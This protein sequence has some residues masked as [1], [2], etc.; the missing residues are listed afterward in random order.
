MHIRC[1]CRLVPLP[2]G[3]ICESNWFKHVHCNHRC[4][5]N[6]WTILN[7]KCRPFSFW[8]VLVL[9]NLLWGNFISF[10]I[11]CFLSGLQTLFPIT[12]WCF[13]LDLFGAITIRVEVHAYMWKWP[14]Y[15]TVRSKM[16]ENDDCWRF[17]SIPIYRRN[18][19]KLLFNWLST[20]YTK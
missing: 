4:Q 19:L 3:S 20:R 14:S 2:I 10:F 9:V 13:D 8:S 17:I 18:Y 12:S 11:T 15:A 6:T 16:L 5:V 1:C 7:M